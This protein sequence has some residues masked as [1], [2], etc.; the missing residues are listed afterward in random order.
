[1]SYGWLSESTIAPRK[2]RSLQVPKGSISVLHRLIQKHTA[3]SNS[4][5]KKSTKAKKDPFEKRNP[6][7]ELRNRVDRASKSTTCSRVR[8]R[9]EAKSR[10][11][12]AMLEGRVS[13]DIDN[14]ESLV[15]FS[16]KREL[17][18]AVC[19]LEHDSGTIL[20][21]KGDC[22]SIVVIIDL[23]T[24]PS[25]PE[26]VANLESLDAVSAFSDEDA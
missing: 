13:S 10:L 12:D 7:V 8:Q 18:N 22:K 4:S 5:S 3:D 19:T 25:S 9:L 20:M 2:G 23:L 21:P 16:A 6:G 26:S 11:Y 15:D 14:S 1:M 17:D 24:G